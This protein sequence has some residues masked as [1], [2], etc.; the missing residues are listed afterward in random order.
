MIYSVIKDLV[1]SL[2]CLDTTYAFFK[3]YLLFIRGFT[4]Q[5]I[6]HT[7]CF[8]L[9]L[10]RSKLLTHCCLRN[11]KTDLMP[12]PWRQSLKSGLRY[13]AHKKHLARK[14]KLSDSHKRK[15]SKVTEAFTN[16]SCCICLMK[17]FDV[18]CNIM[19]GNC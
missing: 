10:N 12:A 11:Q 7:L 5:D 4:A 2:S 19:L 6:T 9:F 15:V 1:W 18:L 14:I 16:L 17:W 3:I 13:S 8:F